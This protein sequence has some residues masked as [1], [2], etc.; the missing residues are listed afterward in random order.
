[1]DASSISLVFVA[2]FVIKT[3][4]S[5]SRVCQKK[6]I[7]LKKVEKCALTKNQEGKRDINF[8][9]RVIKIDECGKIES[10]ASTR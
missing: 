6:N 7:D 10:V 1:L 2:K 8:V 5:V 4:N 3:C 9:Q